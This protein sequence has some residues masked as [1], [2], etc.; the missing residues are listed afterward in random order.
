MHGIRHYQP[1][2]VHLIAMKP[3]LIGGLA[4]RFAPV[5]HTVV[6]LTGL[7][8]MGVMQTTK[9]RTFRW[10]L[11]RHV[12]SIMKTPGNWLMIENPDDLAFLEAGG[13]RT[14]ER[15][16]ILGGAGIDPHAFPAHAPSSNAIP[17]AAYVGRMIRSKGVDV[18]IE[19]ARELKLRGV[20]L[21]INLYGPTDAD[22]PEAIPATELERWSAE[23]LVHWHGPTR[24]VAAVWRDADINVMPTL[25]G[26]GL[27]RSLLEAAASA[28]PAIVTHVPGCRS[29]V[30]NGIEGLVVA[31]GEPDDLADALAQLAADPALRQRMGQA[32]RARVLDG[33]TIPQVAAQ[34]EAS[35][36]AMAKNR[37]GTC[38]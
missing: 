23:G 19:A 18:L 13:T 17:T 16:T 31:A 20:Q 33:Y 1:D 26:E 30:R 9:M 10:V 29:F 11:R 7:G 34:Y 8:F 12:A 21:S 6:H 38:T 4:Q 25:G 28:R 35:Y 24:D 14:Q 22:N 5:P 36:R 37:A 15:H 3:I 27:P 32:A 2:A